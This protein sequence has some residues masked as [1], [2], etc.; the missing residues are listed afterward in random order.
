MS[1]NDETAALV[2]QHASK[3]LEVK[4]HEIALQEKQEDTRR[5][6]IDSATKVALA[7]IE[8]QATDLKDNRQQY[9]TMLLKRHRFII[10]IVLIMAILAGFALINGA[11]DMVVELLKAVAL[12]AAGGFGGFHYGKSKQEK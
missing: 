11:K 7:Q 5:F 2:I 4:R 10:V 1:L 12:F 8:A 6:E 9:N 3:E